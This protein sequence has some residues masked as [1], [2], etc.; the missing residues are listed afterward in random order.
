[1]LH[2]TQLQKLNYPY[3][4]LHTY[5]TFGTLHITSSTVLP[6][7]CLPVSTLHEHEPGKDQ[8]QHIS[9]HSQPKKLHTLLS[10]S[11]IAIPNPLFS[12]NP[13]PHLRHLSL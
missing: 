12:F 11:D 8:I 4:S 7:L 5:F 6:T 1:M 3:S 13:V 10:L 9:I 2:P